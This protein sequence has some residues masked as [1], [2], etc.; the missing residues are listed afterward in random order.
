MLDKDLVPILAGVLVIVVGIGAMAIGSEKLSGPTPP[1]QKID[2]TP[3]HWERFC[4]DNVLYYATPMLT[5]I[6]PAYNIDGS[7]KSCDVS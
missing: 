4:F 7:L 2:S 6:T 5:G 3:P 1:K